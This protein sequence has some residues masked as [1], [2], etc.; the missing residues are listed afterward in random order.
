M[1]AINHKALLT[2]DLSAN[3]N[4]A[5][6]KTVE[7]CFTCMANNPLD[8]TVGTCMRTLMGITSP[9]KFT[10]WYVDLGEVHSVYNI[11]I[12]FKDYGPRYGKQTLIIF[13]VK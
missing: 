7:S 4:A 11:R 9:E 12:Q 1:S 10:W 2:D 13:I 8:S 3:K 5:E 6:Y